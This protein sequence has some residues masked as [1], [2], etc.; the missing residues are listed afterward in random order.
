M[1]GISDAT[2]GAGTLDEGWAATLAGGAAVDGD[3]LAAGTLAWDGA[4]DAQAAIKPAAMTRSPI[5]TVRR[6][7]TTIG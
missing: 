1:A 2:G 3:G 4:A 5:A 7:S 6:G